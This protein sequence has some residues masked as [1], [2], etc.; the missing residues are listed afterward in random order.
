M[1]SD[2]QCLNAA[3]V[4]CRPAFHP[5]QILATGAAPDH[6]GM[7]IAATRALMLCCV[8]PT[9]QCHMIAR[10]LFPSLLCFLRITHLVQQYLHGLHQLPSAFVACHWLS[11]VLAI[12][13]WCTGDIVDSCASSSTPK[14]DW[15]NMMS[16][17]FAGCGT[18][19][20][21]NA[22]FDE[23]CI[24]GQSSNTFKVVLAL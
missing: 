13:L 19:T 6:K 14:C 21:S 4:M 16:V 3:F 12:L 23:V 22:S 10:L 7:G 11:W 8:I 5:I 17:T 24:S 18:S 9:L 2:M 20:A 15:A 1:H